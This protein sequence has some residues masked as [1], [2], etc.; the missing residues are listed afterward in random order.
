MNYIFKKVFYSVLTLFFITIIVFTLFEVMPSS[1]IMSKL[2]IDRA[3]DSAVIESLNEKYNMDKSP[4]YRYT[5][6]MKKLITHKPIESILYEGKDVNKLILDRL[7]LT[8]K[9]SF[10]SLFLS[11]IIAIPLTL[12][13]AINRKSTLSSFIKNSSIVFIATPSFLLGIILIGIF[14]NFL[15]LF[16]VTSGSLFLPIVTLTLP[17]VSLIIRYLLP[18]MKSE[19]KEDYITLLKT[20]GLTNKE[21]ILTHVLKNSLIPVIAI[22]SVIFTSILTGT[23]I[24]ENI[25]VLNGTGR[26]M[27]NAINGSDYLLIEVIVLYYSAIILICNIISDLLYYKVDKRISL[28]WILQKNVFK[29]SRLESVYV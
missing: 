20:K 1:P 14:C 7:P 3:G 6:F 11:L 28:Q 4:V 18:R 12:Q 16:S 27:V 21:I 17:A 23:V 5:D 10:I 25:F 22:S 24:V 13:I 19:V 9:L 29:I 8:L 2:S 26:L 15:G